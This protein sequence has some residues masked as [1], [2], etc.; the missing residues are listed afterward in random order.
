MID[1]NATCIEVQLRD[2]IHAP[3]YLAA[4]PLNQTHSRYE[5]EQ[6]LVSKAVLKR[7]K[8]FFSG[9]H[10]ARQALERAEL[11]V[12]SLLR[13]SLGNPLWPSSVVGS[14]TH[15]HLLGMA[16]VTEG[17]HARGIG[18]DLIE[19]PGLVEVDLAN[20]IM[21]PH[22]HSLPH[23]TAL[24][25]SAQALAFSIKESVVK[26]TSP[27]IGHYMDLLDIQLHH[28]NHGIIARV[29]DFPVQ[30][31]CLALTTNLGLVTCCYIPPL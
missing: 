25:V 7:K 18:L 6:Q 19:N 24:D 16:V 11:P 14:I 23:S 3:L 29:N 27:H 9:R 13:G 5:A 2:F 20:L 28:S 31:P 21:H 10:L 15:D 17:R 1:A 30:L 12:T 8:E 4:G 22:E 26:A